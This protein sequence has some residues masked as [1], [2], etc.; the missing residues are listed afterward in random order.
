MIEY[1]LLVEIDKRGQIVCFS[2]H[3]LDLFSS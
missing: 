2:F 3:F 1:D